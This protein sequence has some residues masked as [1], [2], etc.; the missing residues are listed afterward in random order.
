MG[1]RSVLKCLLP[2]CLRKRFRKDRPKSNKKVS[3][4]A[5]SEMRDFSEDAPPQNAKVIDYTVYSLNPF[6][7]TVHDLERADGVFH[8]RCRGCI[9][10]DRAVGKG[11][12]A[13]RP[14]I[15]ST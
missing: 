13:V 15:S 10:C 1:L 6:T 2:P 11:K 12:Y 9:D 4:A 5:K 3:F 7:N 14:V 8:R